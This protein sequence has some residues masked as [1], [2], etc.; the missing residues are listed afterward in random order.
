MSKSQVQPPLSLY[1]HMPWCVHKCPY[2]DFNSHEARGSVPEREYVEALLADLDQELLQARGRALVSIFIGG[3]TPSLFSPEAID[4]LLAGVRTRCALAPD[5]E[6]T[7]EANPGTIDA[8]KFAELRATGVNRLSIGVQ[9]FQSDALQRVGRIHGRREAVAAAERAHAA[10][11]ESFNLD[12]MFGLP[13]QSLGDALADVHTAMDLEPAHISHYQ[14]TLEPNTLFHARPPVL[15]DEDLVAQMQDA[16]QQ[17]FR[18]RGYAQYEVSAYAQTGHACRHNLN[19]WEFGDYLGVGAGAHGKHTDLET[20][21]VTRTWKRKQPRDYMLHAATAMRIAG[22]RR[23]RPEDV[24]LEFMMNA[25]RLVDGVPE[26]LF[27]ER[28]GL[29]L[30]QVAGPLVEAATRGLLVREDGRLRTTETGL[31]YLNDLLALFLPEEPGY[32]G[33]GAV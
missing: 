5:C 32:V 1:V 11:F 33:A 27:A 10:G 26:A 24:A 9:S 19:Y 8:G 25:L 31:R 4:G 22:H 28:T 14:L 15:P 18:A 20:G 16:C 7:L 30:S 6:I 21:A 12:L 13:G 29:S 23:L 2:C 3:G 17:A